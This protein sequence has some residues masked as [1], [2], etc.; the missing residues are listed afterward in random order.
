MANSG[1]EA[2]GQYGHT[3]FLYL[4]AGA[5]GGSPLLPACATG[6]THGRPWPAS[7]GAGGAQAADGS[8][9]PEA[10]GCCLGGLL[11][12]DQVDIGT[13]ASEAAHR[14]LVA[15][16]AGAVLEEAAGEE[17]VDAGSARAEAGSAQARGAGAQQRGAGV[18][19]DSAGAV[20]ASASPF[21]RPGVGV[22]EVN[23]SDGRDDDAG[24]G[25]GG[26]WWRVQQPHTEA[27]VGNDHVAVAD[28]PALPFADAAAA[29]SCLGWLSGRQE[30]GGGDEERTK[31][32]RH[33]DR[34]ACGEPLVWRVNRRVLTAS[35][36]VG[37]GDEEW[38]GGE[39]AGAWRQCSL[40]LCD[41]GEALV[42][43]AQVPSAAAGLEDTL[44]RVLGSQASLGALEIPSPLTISFYLYV[45]ER[46]PSG[47]G[48]CD[49]I[50]L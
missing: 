5:A 24:S 37:S 20:S 4:A 25:S 6:G 23:E 15:P 50:T 17:A 3:A 31:E 41:G 29:S 13:R 12:L 28:A 10:G 33:T 1:S 42:F 32:G 27:S 16:A 22:W 14:Y 2:E 46:E 49:M 45:P 30:P 34:G 8:E 7:G 44:R 21:S 9:E 19:F 36:E 39:G 11:V 48:T 43:G 40:G 47:P 18:L 26:R 38:R 35:P